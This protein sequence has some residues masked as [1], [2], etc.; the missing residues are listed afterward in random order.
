MI[1]FGFWSLVAGIII[2]DYMSAIGWFV[3][4]IFFTWIITLLYYLGGMLFKSKAEFMEIYK[5]WGYAQLV[6]G[7]S[8][9]INKLFT[10]N[11]ALLISLLLEVWCIIIAYK[12]IK[13]E[14]RLKPWKALIIA[15]IP[16]IILIIIVMTNSL[17]LLSIILDSG[18]VNGLLF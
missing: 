17:T 18:L 10:T 11:L 1:L 7:I 13:T 4:A 14:S 6:V 5:P 3:E 15:L 8:F 2:Q 16:I 9:L 12:I